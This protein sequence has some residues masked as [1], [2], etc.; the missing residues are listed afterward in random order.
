MLYSANLPLIYPAMIWAFPGVCAFFHPLIGSLTDHCTSRFGKRRPYILIALLLQVL[1]SIIFV[2][3]TN[4]C[5]P[6]SNITHEILHFP[7]SFVNFI[8]LSGINAAVG[9][10]T[11]MFSF[12]VLVA[13]VNIEMFV[14]REV[15]F[16][17]ATPA[18]KTTA[19]V[20]FNTSAG[21]GNLVALLM[22]AYVPP[23]WNYNIFIVLVLTIVT[24]VSSNETP[25]VEQAGMKRPGV[26]RP[27]LRGI[28]LIFTN[29]HF[30]LVGIL[31]YLKEVFSF[32]FICYATLCFVVNIKGAEPKGLC[33]L[34]FSSSFFAFSFLIVFFLFLFLFFC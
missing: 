10:Y 29:R 5:F 16:D 21:I 4:G 18:R 3:M 14:C 23:L 15:I 19:T 32:P 33:V 8:W 6:S 13:S 22:A 1:G 9:P 12:L 28:K 24:L 25:M 27:T 30:F 26:F 2:G 20:I 11:A 7:S 34:F 31:H 17:L